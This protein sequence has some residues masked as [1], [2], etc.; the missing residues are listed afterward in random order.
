MTA[1][2]ILRTYHSWRE[3]LA[4]IAEDLHS[5]LAER[6]LR[7]LAE[8]VG[9]IG[10]RLRSDRLRVVFTGSFSSGKSSLIN[11]LL[12]S[13]AIPVAAYP[14]SPIILSLEWSPQPFVQLGDAEGNSLSSHAVTVTPDVLDRYLRGLG[15][16]REQ[17][18]FKFARIGADFELCAQGLEIV[19][20]PGLREDIQFQ[21]LMLQS[22]GSA[23]AVIFT[24]SILN[25][26]AMDE[27]ALAERVHTLVG[28]RMFLVLTRADQVDSNNSREILS[29][30]HQQLSGR[31]IGSLPIFLVS[32]RMALEA[33]EA[34]H[35]DLLAESGLPTLETALAE[36]L[37]LEVARPRLLATAADIRGQTTLAR[38]LNAE[39][40][41]QSPDVI[42]DLER[43]LTRS[44]SAATQINAMLEA[45]AARAADEAG[46]MAKEFFFS[47]ADQIPGW[48]EALPP[49]P[50]SS[51][52]PMKTAE[53][54][55]A[56]AREIT[57]RL[58]EKLEQEVS[59]WAR[60]D[61]S[62]FLRSHISRTENELSER[63]NDLMQPS[64]Q[65]EGI[66]AAIPT[67]LESSLAAGGMP[68]RP[69][70][71]AALSAALLT[72]SGY[73]LIGSVA[74][75]TALMWSKK[76]IPELRRRVIFQAQHAVQS[77]AAAF[78]EQVSHSVHDYYSDVQRRVNK[79]LDERASLLLDV[80]SGGVRKHHQAGERLRDG[81][82]PFDNYLADVEEKLASIIREIDS[83][84]A[85]T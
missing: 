17:G 77:N 39:D 75:V 6:E 81:D 78:G 20:T 60:D 43:Q 26:F 16:P 27:I 66:P 14:T 82:A 25:P 32:A 56:A 29:Y 44:E 30:T 61:L 76:A 58:S 67:T 33:K 63:F 38:I 64:L 11:A 72:T 1:L 7:A 84:Y 47:L 5:A 49:K 21:Q 2:A 57:D 36:R 54:V 23:D 51:L 15:D 24:H 70:Y 13:E 69:V 37:M 3:S 50:K 34:G 83:F 80:G 4:D 42:A 52:S 18:R 12:G 28:G 45:D 53:Q 41:H 31:L 73:G 62:M 10:Y 35:P 8:R 85:S 71:I 65:F 59:R 74:T 40:V 46:R 79:A 22:L 19:D 68:G 48:A 9:Q 55:R